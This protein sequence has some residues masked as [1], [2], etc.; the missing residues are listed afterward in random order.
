METNLVQSSTFQILCKILINGNSKLNKHGLY[1]LGAH[2]K[3]SRRENEADIEKTGE[4]EL[5][6]LHNFI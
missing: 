4:G 6:L 1:L 5:H 2:K 3:S